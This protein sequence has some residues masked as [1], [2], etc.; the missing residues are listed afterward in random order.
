MMMVMFNVTAAA[1]PGQRS[2]LQAIRTLS[3][4]SPGRHCQRH[5]NPVSYSLS[6]MHHAFKA[7]QALI[8][9]KLLASDHG[10]PRLRFAAT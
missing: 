4:F 3:G 2:M 6:K 10:E 9:S 8:S 7:L 5:C 1:K